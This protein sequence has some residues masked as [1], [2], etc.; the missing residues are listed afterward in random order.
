M[1]DIIS[2]KACWVSAS[3]NASATPISFIDSAMRQRNATVFQK[4]CGIITS[5]GRSRAINRVSRPRGQRFR[6]ARHSHAQGRGNLAEFIRFGRRDQ[7]GRKKICEVLQSGTDS[8]GF[9]LQNAGRN[10]QKT[11]R[12]QSR[13]ILSRFQGGITGR[14]QNCFS[15]TQFM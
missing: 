12:P 11:Y 4:V 15:Q 9:E 7:R 2:P 6:R 10:R 3:S 5:R 14:R 13:L 1:D 8:F